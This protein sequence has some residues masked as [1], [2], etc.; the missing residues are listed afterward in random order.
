M[1]GLNEI[2]ELGKAGQA[3]EA[4][5]L[6]KADLEAGKPWGQLTTAWALRYW[7]EDDARN[8]RY[9]QLV[10][11]LDELQTLD[12]IPPAELDKIAENI[13]FWIGYIAKKFF[14]EKDFNTPLRLST[15]FSKV[16]KYSFK[17]GVGYSMLLE[18]FIRCD[19]WPELLDFFKWWRLGNLTAEDFKPVE[20]KNGRTIQVTLAE[21]AY[22][23]KSKAL[24]RLNDPGEIEMFLPEM[25]TLMSEH[26]EMTYP[27]YFY[28]KLLLALGDTSEDALKVIVP[29]ARKKITEFWVW[30]LISDVFVN[31]QEKQLACLLRAVN[32]RTQ[33]NFLGKVRI[34]LA[35]IYIRLNK[36]ELAKNQIDKVTKNYLQNG[37]RL[38]N[39]IDNWIHQPWFATINSTDKETLDYMSITNSI[40][41][42][43]AEE[44][45]AIVTYIDPKTH[46]SSLVYGLEKR[47]T[48]KINHKV[49]Q[50]DVLKINYVEETNGKPRIISSIRCDLPDDLMYGKHV[51]GTIRK[52]DDQEH[53]Q[54]RFGNEKAF[55]SAN[56]VCKY[57]IKDGDS[58]QCRIAYDYDK[59]RETWNWVCVKIRK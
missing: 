9:D 12:Q 2:K 4:Y 20:L 10:S 26:P 43:G 19:A 6:A 15:L 32:C 52:R 7:A 8:G 55:L 30:Q 24:L 41:F 42:D 34:K 5:E 59:R 31:D 14:P 37:W 49:L 44:A 51:S 39:Q 58:V 35:D 47:M 1:A 22:I 45:I 3:K 50:G 54:V 36:L 17:P 21:R 46:R 40:L 18:G 13:V 27:G 11:H 57:K 16:R 25:D 53:A 56:L 23:A 48:Q 28:G 38:P 33:E 29:F